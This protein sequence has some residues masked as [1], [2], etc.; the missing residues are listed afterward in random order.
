MTDTAPGPRWFHLGGRTDPVALGIGLLALLIRAAFLL[1]YPEIQAQNDEQLQ[2]ALGVLAVSFGHEV[3]GRWAPAYTAFLAGVFRLAGA[4]P[5]TAKAVQVLLST[6]TVGFVYGLVRRTGTR[7]AARIAGL[8]AALY[9]SFIAF[10]HYLF[11]ETLFLFFLTAAAYFL[12]R[13]AGRRSRLELFAGAVCLG[14]AVLTRSTVLYFL[15]V[16][17][18]FEL[19]RGR[20]DEARHAALALGVALLLLLPWTLRNALHYRDF[21]LIDATIGY[22]AYNAFQ[23]KLFAV[24]LGYRQRLEVVRPR[25]AT[26]PVRGRTPL[27]SL[28]ELARHFPPEGRRFYLSDNRFFAAINVARMEATGNLAAVQRCEI[29]NALEFILERPGLFAQ[30]IAERAYAFW[31]PNSFLLRAVNRGFYAGG[32]L[33]AA[34]YPLVKAAVVIPYLVVVAAAILAAGC[35]DAPRYAAWLALLALYFTLAHALSIADSRHRLPLLPLVIALGAHWLARPRW[36]EGGA[37]GV[38]AAALL[39]GFAALCVHYLIV[40]LP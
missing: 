9:P 33:D 32:P 7:R 5:F 12:F 3:M 4:E 19:W 15:P 23:E 13:S 38:T 11:S 31:G 40:R 35:R 34:A 14:L 6:A 36:P 1:R 16:W 26:P 24:D 2:Y 30:R 10:S 28:A 29:R 22:V 20:R 8:L 39:A 27:P 18:A 21:L 25:C 17:I 37:R